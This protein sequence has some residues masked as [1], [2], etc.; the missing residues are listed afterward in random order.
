[1][2]ESKTSLNAVERAQQRVDLYVGGE[3][4]RKSDEARHLKRQGGMRGA[5]SFELSFSNLNH[6]VKMQILTQ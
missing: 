4:T 5:H 2:G 3:D 6:L 1:M